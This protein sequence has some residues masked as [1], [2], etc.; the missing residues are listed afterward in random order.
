[1]ETQSNNTFSIKAKTCTL[2][3]KSQEDGDTILGK[4]VKYVIPIYQRPYSWKEEQIRK[5]ISDIFNSFWGTDGDS[6]SEA[7]FIGTMQLSDAKE[8]IDGQQRLTTFLLL[9]KVLKQNYPDCSQLKD[10]TLDWLNTKVNSGEQQL[11]LNEV[12]SSNLTL[13]DETLNPYLKNAYLI[14]ELIEE[15]IKDEEGNYLNFD[16][17]KFS[18]HLLSNIYFVVIETRAGLS[19]TLQIFNAINTTGLDLNGGD[20]F[21][22][23]MYEYL[24]DKKGKDETAFEDISRLYQKI[25][26]LNAELKDNVTDMHG[27]LNIYQYILIAKFNLPTVLYNYATDVFFEHLFDSIFNINQWNHFSNVKNVELSINEIDRIIDARFDWERKWYAKAEDMGCY[28]LMATSRYGKYCDVLPTILLFADK[29][30]DRFYFTRQLS[31]VYAIYSIRFLKAVNEIHRFTYSLIKDILNKPF[32]EIMRTINQK[33]GKPE[34]HNQGWYDLNW[35]LSENLTENDKRKKL[36]CRLSALLEENYQ[37]EDQKEIE[38]LKDKL[39]HNDIDIEHIQSYHDRDGN[40]REDVWN[41]WKEAINSIGNLMVLESRLNRSISNK[42]YNEKLVRYPESA[43]KIARKQTELA[44]WN[45][46]KC[47]ERKEKETMKIVVYLFS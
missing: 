30:A 28:K 33:I 7:M 8:I 43:Y 1:M 41:E 4:N 16:I 29:N 35:F 34:D 13:N 32:E 20:I 15:E 25:D 2:K 37:T 40:K 22:I 24:K 36:I 14:N 45:L 10:I 9:L 17:D 18:N 3:L 46:K 44:E 21:K 26:Q 12:I 19:K 39:F 23:R 42:P 5:F 27:I 31:K 11:Y 38:N 47:L 6:E